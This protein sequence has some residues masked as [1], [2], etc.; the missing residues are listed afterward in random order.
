MA[1]NFPVGE[2][3]RDHLTCFQ[4]FAFCIEE[5]GL[6][7]QR[8]CVSLVGDSLRFGSDFKSGYSPRGFLKHNAIQF[9]FPLPYSREFCEA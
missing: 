6:P 2:N 7:D 3:V 5:N 1:D 9:S 8:L 4:E